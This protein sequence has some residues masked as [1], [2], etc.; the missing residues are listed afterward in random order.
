M[1]DVF[2]NGINIEIDFLYGKIPESKHEIIILEKLV[3][4]LKL[5]GWTFN[6]NMFSMTFIFNIF[7]MS[8]EYT[9]FSVFPVSLFD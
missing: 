6:P 3:K 2:R 1:A 7:K 4:F 5:G 8:V 9:V